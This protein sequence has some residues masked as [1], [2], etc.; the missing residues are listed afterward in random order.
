LFHT[1]ICGIDAVPI[2]FSTSSTDLRCISMCRDETSC[3]WSSRS[4]FATSASVARNDSTSVCGSR[5]TKP[6]V[7]VSVAR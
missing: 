3:R 5:C 7:P 4:A 2:S 6:T 1:V